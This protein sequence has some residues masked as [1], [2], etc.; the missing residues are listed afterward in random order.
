MIN[1]IHKFIYTRITKTAS[2]SLFRTLFETEMTENDKWIPP[3]TG[4]WDFPEADIE[5]KFLTDVSDVWDQDSKHYPMSVI[6]KVTTDWVYN[7]YFKFGFVR[8]PFDK[9]VSAYA[10]TLN[11]YLENEPNSSYCPKDFKTWVKTLDVNDK[12]GNQYPYVEGCDFIGRFENLENDFKRICD[13]IGIPMQKLPHH[14]KTD[15]KHYTEYY[16]DETRQI[17][18]EKYAKDIEYFGY[19]FGVDQK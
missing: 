4:T 12:Y 11:W 1:H 14:N 17:V 18:A 9:L 2:H 3:E 16:D 7:N 19:E 10:Y 15:H 13:R 8:N 6:K 5:I